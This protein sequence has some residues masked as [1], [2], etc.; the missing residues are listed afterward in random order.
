[1]PYLLYSSINGHK[2]LILAK[3]VAPV[4]ICV[5][6]VEVNH[7][8]Q[9]SPELQ[10]LKRFQQFLAHPADVL[11]L[12]NGSPYGLVALDTGVFLS[13]RGQ[14][15]LCVRPSMVSL[16][17]VDSALMGFPSFPRLHF[18]GSFLCG[19]SVV[20]EDVQSAF[21]SSEEELVYV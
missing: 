11:G 3:Y 10:I 5:V 15:S 12:V 17:A 7:K 16:P 9:D 14:A 21:S 8:T 1:M 19:P 20:R 4:P 13:G 2:L 18:S 6:K